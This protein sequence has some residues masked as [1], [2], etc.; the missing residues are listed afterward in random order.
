[1]IGAFYSFTLFP[2]N[3]IAHWLFMRATCPL[4]SS[5]R[6]ADPSVLQF[7]WVLVLSADVGADAAKTRAWQGLNAFA[8]RLT[9]SSGPESGDGLRATDF[10]RFG[11]I[12]LDIFASELGTSDQSDDDHNRDGG[13]RRARRDQLK[14]PG[15]PEEATAARRAN[16]MASVAVAADWLACC[17]PQLQRRL[18]VRGRTGGSEG[19]ETTAMDGQGAGGGDSRSGNGGMEKWQRWKRCWVALANGEHARMLDNDDGITR[20]MARQAKELMDKLDTEVAA[21]A[22]DDADE[23]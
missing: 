3:K 2:Q 4:V 23:F 22:R 14:T 15:G 12:A 11:E 8:A 20:N 1:M 16:V 19:T 7:F 18:L 10:S 5:D 13:S 21:R 9:R 17:G 6:M